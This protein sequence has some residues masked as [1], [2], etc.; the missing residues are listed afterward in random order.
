MASENEWTLV[1]HRRRSKKQY[2][3]NN[4]SDDTMSSAIA[5]YGKKWVEKQR[6]TYLKNID[7]IAKIID[8]QFGWGTKEYYIIID[9]MYSY[10]GEQQ[11][12]RIRNGFEIRYI[13]RLEAEDIVHI[14]CDKEVKNKDTFLNMYGF[15]IN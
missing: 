11:L 10:Y 9:N 13:T 12:D 7:I 1:V 2:N 3:N 15:Y 5:K 8:T 6:N 14:L 4:E